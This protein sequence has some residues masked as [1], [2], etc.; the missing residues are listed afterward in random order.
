MIRLVYDNE[1]QAADVVRSAGLNLETDAG[2]ETAVT[3]SLYTDA[4]ASA[5]DGLADGQNPRGWWGEQFLEPAGPLG[6]KLW[7][8][9]RHNLTDDTVLLA[10]DYAKEALAWMVTV[11]AALAVSA[12]AERSRARRDMVL[13]Y[14]V[15]ERPRKGPLRFE[16]PWEVQFGV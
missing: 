10:A 4:R 5:E 15:I 8:L 14:P 11:R 9:R 6:S 13:I 12:T 7:I 16:R 3:I 1:K 2:L